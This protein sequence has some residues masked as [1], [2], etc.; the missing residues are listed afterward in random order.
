MYQ[1]KN[2]SNYQNYLKEIAKEL[3]LTTFPTQNVVINFTLFVI[4]FTAAMAVYLG[5][6]DIG[7]GKATISFIETLKTSEFANSLKVVKDVAEVATTTIIN[8]TSTN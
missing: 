6:L 5:A 2:M 8:A 4:L 1:I 3:R 7:F